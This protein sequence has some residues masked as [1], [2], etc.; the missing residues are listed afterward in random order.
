MRSMPEGTL[1]EDTAVDNTHRVIVV[2]PETYMLTHVCAVAIGI[3]RRYISE[4]F[5]MVGEFHSLLDSAAVDAYYFRA[6]ISIVK[7][8]D[9][10]A[11]N[12]SAAQGTCVV[13]SRNGAQV[14][15][16]MCYRGVPRGAVE[17]VLRLSWEAD[18]M[19]HKMK[20]FPNGVI[21][22]KTELFAFMYDVN[23]NRERLR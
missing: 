18:H 8:S 17:P 5:L 11:G 12:I 9:R 23:A 22:Y 21:K 19:R 15:R 6:G 14:S 16:R 4:D 13:V 1:P 7:V 3:E 2:T 10:R 20:V